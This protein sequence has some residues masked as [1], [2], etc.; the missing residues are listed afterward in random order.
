[1]TRLS[2]VS[3]HARQMRQVMVRSILELSV[4]D[5]TPWHQRKVIL[6]ARPV[7]TVF[8]KLIHILTDDWGP[9]FSNRQPLCAR[10]LLSSEAPY[11]SLPHL[12]TV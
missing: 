9:H 5:L 8:L 1:M 12:A 11:L 3:G 2:L 10:S 6:S 7:A 4:L